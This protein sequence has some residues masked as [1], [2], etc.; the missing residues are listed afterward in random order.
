MRKISDIVF[1]LLQASETALESM[2][3]GILNFSA[4]AEFVQPEVE[5]LAWKPVKK[6]TIVVALSRIAKSMEELHALR[7][8]VVLDEL[9]IKSPLCDITYEKT[10][11]TAKQ[12]RTLSQELGDKENTFLIVTQGMSEITIITLEE[13]EQKI[14]RH[15]SHPPKSIYRDL[16]GVSVRF[17][18]QYLIQPN[19]IYSILSLLAAKRVNLIE[20]VSTY[21][22]LTMVIEKREMEV[23]ITALNRSFK[24][25]L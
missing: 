11:H 22:E 14:T 13:D 17:S 4:Y 16:V 9:S 2:R 25:T 3:A 1:E 5:K 20:I 7:P 24:A 10:K 18:E 19:V 12:I 8:Q 6:T 15:F 21:T 23:A